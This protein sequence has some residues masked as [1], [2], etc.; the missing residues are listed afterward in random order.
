MPHHFIRY[1]VIAVL[2]AL[3]LGGFSVSGAQTQPALPLGDDSRIAEANLTVT[4]FAS[5]VNFPVGLAVLPD[6]SLLVGSSDPRY[7]SYFGSVGQ[8][9]RFVDADDDGVADGPPAIVSDGLPGGIAAV[10][11]AGEFVAVTTT[12]PGEEG[13]TL[14]RKGSDWSNPMTEVGRIAFIFQGA[15][16]TSYGL[17]VRETP[18]ESGAHDLIFNIG[19]SGNET[20]GRAVQ[21]RG[22]I[23]AVL[24]DATLY[25]VTLRDDGE[26]LSVSDPILVA[27]GLRNVMGMAFEP[28]SGD[29]LLVD[30]GI[31]GLVNP[32]DAHSADELN[33]LPVD[34]LGQ[35]P[36]DFGFPESYVLYPSGEVIGERG[37]QPEVAFLPLDGD[38]SEG[39]A[40]LAVAP[41]D[42]PDGL[43]DGVFVGFHGQYDLT[44][45]Q[46]D[47]NPLV[48]V[49]FS[50]DDYIHFVPVSS[51]GV[52][53]LNSLAST[54]DALYIADMCATGTLT[55]QD[56]CG[57]IYRIK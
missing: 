10:A 20:H 26:T 27:T 2:L 35:E 29:L 7:G 42:F 52:G 14:L 40:H 49:D 36:V 30:N 32:L 55:A 46:N 38:K 15:A 41:I 19:A 33:R 39:P 31:D 53:H 4:T 9:L 3:L 1:S 11:V 12:A 44:G 34:R 47:E 16:H 43:N 48:F 8:I 6:G 24:E 28:D 56:P 50:A 21:A 23:D 25:M 54:D 22:L 45:E 5:G 51:P 57:V 18:G 17:A 13:I 37:V